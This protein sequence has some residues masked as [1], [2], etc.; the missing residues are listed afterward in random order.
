[1]FL[2]MICGFILSKLGDRQVIMTTCT[3]PPVE[4]DAKFIDVEG[5]LYFD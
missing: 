1:M 4:S 2:L 3:P 5:G